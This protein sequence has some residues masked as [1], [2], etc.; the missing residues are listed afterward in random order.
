MA[1][2]RVRGIYALKRR[3]GEELDARRRRRAEEPLVA[4]VPARVPA[5]VDSVARRPEAPGPHEPAEAFADLLWFPT[6]G[7]KTEAYLGRRRLRDGASGACR[8]IVGGL[9]GGARPHRHHALHAAP[10]DAAAVPARRDADLRD[11]D[12]PP[13][14][15]RRRQWGAEPFTLGLWVGNKVTPGTTETVAPGHRGHP[16]Q[17]PQPRRHRV[18][19]AAHELPVVRLG[20]SARARHR[21]RQG[22]RAHRHLLRRQARQLRVLA[23]RSRAATPHPGLPVKVVDEE[24]YHRPPTMMIATV[25]KFAMMAWRGEVR[26]LFGQVR[27]GVRAARFALAGRTTAA[28]GTERARPHAAAKVKPVRADAA[29]GPDHPG[30][31]PPDQ[32][33][34]RHDGRPLR[35]RRRRA[36]RAG[37][38]AR[39][40]CARRSS[41]RP[42][43]SDARTSRCATSSCGASRSSRR[44]ALDVEDNFF[45][46]QRSVDEQAGAALHGHLLAGQLA[47]CGAHPHLH[48]VPHGGAGALRCASARSPTRT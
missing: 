27:R 36:L 45:A 9:D 48:R 37:S 6:G 1:R 25:D 22:R 33:S 13:R 47:A 15:R 40:R 2:Q 29:A 26:T 8:A 7:G 24:I 39:R 12:H 32:R 43:R 19:R 17:G 38:S 3:R 21:G 5:A 30:R 42:R 11:G 34:A 44:T 14:A 16:R 35:D 23:R 18:A 28:A 10:A 20:D 41:P 31:V 46:V 4:P